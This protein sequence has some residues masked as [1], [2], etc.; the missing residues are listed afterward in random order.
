MYMNLLSALLSSTPLPHGA[1]SASSAAMSGK[2]DAD[3]NDDTSSAPAFTLTPPNDVSGKLP[4]PSRANNGNRGNT[5]QDDQRPD[6]SAAAAESPAMST[7]G[8]RSDDEDNNENSV[9]S[10]TQTASALMALLLQL[11]QV[12]APSPHTPQEGSVEQTEASQGDANPSD[13][14]TL[15][16][17]LKQLAALLQTALQQAAPKA[18][19]ATASAAVSA[20]DDVTAETDNS[21]KDAAPSATDLAA[22]ILSLLQQPGSSA[23]TQQTAQTGGDDTLSIGDAPASTPATALTSALNQLAALLEKATAPTDS[24]ATSASQD[25]ATA[26]QPA[27]ALS[28]DDTQTTNNPTPSLLPA[29]SKEALQQA[30]ARVVNA[31]TDKHAAANSESQQS[32]SHADASVTPAIL[33]FSQPSQAPVQHSDF[34]KHVQ[35]PAAAPELPVTD[36]V[37][38]QIKNAVADNVSQI[39]VQLHPEDLGKIDVQLTT[40]AEGKTSVTVTS[41][42]RNTLALLQ[43]DARALRDALQDIGLKTDAGSL[44]FN[45]RDPGQD[46]RNASKQQKAS[47]TNVAAIG[48]DD[49]HLGFSTAG[50]LYRISVQ[51]G[52]DIRV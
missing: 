48:E 24:N 4:A 17:L 45:L 31:L 26:P 16:D 43:N 11:Q 8:K 39:R 38:V 32:A 36:Q 49:D 29:S 28:Q 20:A 41:D 10:T 23:P 14:P 1:A 5:S 34:I 2:S 3:K 46:A 27:F 30:V 21:P 40:N 9:E 25:D 19:D 6:T 15:D 13:T 35:Q 12:A 18:E 44:N 33:P 52:L 50:S 7:D 37:V 42:N 22:L 51:Q 47:Y